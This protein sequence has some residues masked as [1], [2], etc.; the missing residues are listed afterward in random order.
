VGSGPGAVGA[1]LTASV[2]GVEEAAATT[3]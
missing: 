1:R 3:R 2:V